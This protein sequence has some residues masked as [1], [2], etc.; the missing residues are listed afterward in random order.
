MIRNLLISG[1]MAIL[2]LLG[3]QMF[4]QATAENKPAKSNDNQPPMVKCYQAVAMPNE[5]LTLTTEQQMKD[6]VRD[7]EGLET[8]YKEGKISKNTYET[9]LKNIKDQMKTLENQK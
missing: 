8:S 4:K 9:R 1:L 3:V 6:L 5:P 7:Q 2:A